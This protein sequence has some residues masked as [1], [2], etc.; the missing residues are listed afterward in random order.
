MLS[1]AIMYHQV[2]MQK[3]SW[4][5]EQQDSKEKAVQQA[6]EAREQHLKTMYDNTL[7]DQLDAA[8][9]NG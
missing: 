3:V 8:M 9:E 7:K 5:E 1:S 6:V 4:F 2:A